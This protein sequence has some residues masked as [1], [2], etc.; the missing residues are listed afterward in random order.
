MRVFFN[1][2]LRLIGIT[3]V[4]AGCN[5]TT[6]D[7]LP[8]PIPTPDLPRAEIL[9][10]PNNVQ[11]IEGTEFNIDIVARDE[12]QGIA[13]IVLLIDEVEVNSATPQEEGP[14][15]VFRVTMNWRASGPGRHVIEAIAYR[16]DETPSDAAVLNV[17]VLAPE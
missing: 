1:S 15:N 12:S 10:P 2:L 14:V 9:E 13:R 8:T 16:P 6:A 4:L 3:F 5:L 11:I 7:R 17:D